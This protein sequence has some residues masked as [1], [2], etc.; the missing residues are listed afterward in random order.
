M[1]SISFGSW[2]KRSK[3]LPSSCL[4]MAT[5][6]PFRCQIFL[7]RKSVRQRWIYEHRPHPPVGAFWTLPAIVDDQPSFPN[8]P[9][10]SG[11]DVG[12]PCCSPNGLPWCLGSVLPT[13]P[14][15]L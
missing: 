8:R 1:P 15:G 11:T 12:G 4:A 7:A 10:L 5:C 9:R 2:W 6:R 13:S 14:R 3:P